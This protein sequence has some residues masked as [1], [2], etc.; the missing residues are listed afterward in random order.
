MDELE[1]LP[2]ARIRNAGAG[3]PESQRPRPPDLG[4]QRRAGLSFGSPVGTRS[5][6]AGPWDWEPG[7]RRV[8][9]RQGSRRWRKPSPSPNN[10]EP[11]P[12]RD[13]RPAP[14]RRLPGPAGGTCSHEMGKHVGATHAVTVREQPIH[15]QRH[16]GGACGLLPRTAVPRG[17]GSPPCRCPP[18][19]CMASWLRRQCEL[20][21]VPPQFAIRQLS[22]NPSTSKCGLIWREGLGRLSKLERGGP[23]LAWPAFVQRGTWDMTRRGHVQTKAARGDR[24]RGVQ[25]GAPAPPLKSSRMWRRQRPSCQGRGDAGLNGEHRMFR[26][27]WL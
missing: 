21:S 10:A 8:P 12:A 3:R 2:A 9:H 11:L 18:P 7:Q 4:G 15:A 5:A 1:P 16:G 25:L 24:P 20:H 19:Q 26:A 13:A 22:P 27:G 23:R 17:S 6:V 14:R